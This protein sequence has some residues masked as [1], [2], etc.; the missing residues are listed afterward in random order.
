MGVSLA[1]KDD[2]K[3]SDDKPKTERIDRRT[4]KQNLKVIGLAMHN[5]RDTYNKFPFAA[6]YAKNDKD[7]KKPLLSWRVAILPFIEEDKLWKEFKLDEPWDS[8]HNKKLLPRMPKIYG[9]SDAKSDGSTFYQAFVG[10]GAAFDDGMKKINKADFTDGTSNTLLVAEADNAVPWTKPEDLPYDPDKPL[11]KLGGLFDDGFHAMFADGS[12]QF[13][14]KDI[15]PETLRALITR[16]G[17]EVVD[18]Y[19]LLEKKDNKGDEKPTKD[20]PK[21]E[22]FLG[23]WSGKWDDTY[24]VRFTITQDPK[25]NELKV[26]YEYE[27]NVGKPLRRSRVTAKLEGNTLRVGRSMDVTISANDPDKGQAIGRFAERRTA[28]LVREKQ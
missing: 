20:Q 18:R 11:P 28:D 21:L 1:A 25:T 19:K 5:F 15:K 12:V 10:K 14:K 4:S 27:Q 24:Q 3:K 2:T 23:K 26:L 17:G 8:D 16:S 9:P 7:R 13:I 22:D 6:M